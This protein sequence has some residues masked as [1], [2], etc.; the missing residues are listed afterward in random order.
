[1]VCNLLSR[2]FSFIKFWGVQVSICPERL[3]TLHQIAAEMVSPG[4]NLVPRGIPGG[5][6]KARPQEDQMT[7]F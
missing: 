5:E 1:M 7:D 3:L 2:K 4:D 6:M